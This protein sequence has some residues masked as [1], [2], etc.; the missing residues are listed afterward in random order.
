[1][2]TNEPA[3]WSAVAGLGLILAALKHRRA[4]SGKRGFSWRPGSKTSLYGL[5][6]T[7]KMVAVDHRLVRHESTSV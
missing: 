1:M 3:F 6:R 5:W 2:P 7:K 4:M